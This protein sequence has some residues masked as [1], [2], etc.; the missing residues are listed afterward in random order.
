MSKGN[1]KP[2]YFFVVVVPVAATDLLA[3]PDAVVV[4]F[5]VVVVVDIAGV[6]VVGTLGAGCEEM[7]AVV[8]DEDTGV[9]VLEGTLVGTVDSGAMVEEV[10]E[11]VDGDDDGTT[12]GSGTDDTLAISAPVL[13]CSVVSVLEDDDDDADPSAIFDEALA[14][15]TAVALLNFSLPNLEKAF[16]AITFRTP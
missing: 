9:V 1:D 5:V 14:V 13:S 7:A 16:A 15:V 11:V 8:V 6:A 4:V 10:G 12:V 2:F 3:V